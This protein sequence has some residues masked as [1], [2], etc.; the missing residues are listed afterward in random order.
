MTIASVDV[1][2]SGLPESDG[3]TLQRSLG[4][5]ASGVVKIK[6]FRDP[7]RVINFTLVG[8]TTTVKNNLATAL[9]AAQDTTLAIT[10]DAHIDFGNG[11]GTAVN[12]Y[13]LGPDLT[14][15]RKEINES[16]TIP[17]SFKYSS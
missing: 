3:R 2:G 7:E 9:I 1:G 5:A 13:W 16:W 15:W 17:L 4:V 11:A 14:E 6:K 10:P 12:V 8:K